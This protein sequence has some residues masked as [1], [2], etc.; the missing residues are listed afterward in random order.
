MK[1]YFILD[2][3][4]IGQIVFFFIVVY[5]TI[6]KKILISMCLYIYIYLLYIITLPIHV[7]YLPTD[8]CIIY[9]K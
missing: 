7:I 1:N 5:R 4:A 8:Y 2:F 6:A 3:Y 9:N